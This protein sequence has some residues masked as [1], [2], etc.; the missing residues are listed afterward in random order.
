MPFLSFEIVHNDLLL[1]ELTMAKEASTSNSIA[2][3]ATSMSVQQQQ[4]DTTSTPIAPK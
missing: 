1:E 2:S 4:S 3:L